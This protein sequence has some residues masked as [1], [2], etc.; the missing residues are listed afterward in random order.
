M[1][2][3]N[4]GLS[5]EDENTVKMKSPVPAGSRRKYRGGCPAP[6][7]HRMDTQG[8]ENEEGQLRESLFLTMK[9]SMADNGQFGEVY[10]AA[11]GARVPRPVTTKGG[12]GNKRFDI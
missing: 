4:R 8:S 3:S 5:S 6:T 12:T 1:L 10:G 2:S 7:S 11:G 9:E